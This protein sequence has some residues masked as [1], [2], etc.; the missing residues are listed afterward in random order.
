MKPILQTI[1]IIA[2]FF[3]L[4]WTNA[5]GLN[6]PQTELNQVERMLKFC[7]GERLKM[8]RS[9]RNMEKNPATVTLAEYNDA[10]EYLKE[11][12]KCIKNT[13]KALDELKK[14]YPEW[15]NNQSVTTNDRSGESGGSAEVYEQELKNLRVN[16]E[17][18][19]EAI[20]SV[21]IPNH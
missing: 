19:M 9:I 14:K 10:K 6:P 12:K 2:C 17:W 21:P 13:A 3:T 16:L 4:P 18:Y 8:E 11:L 20:N 5:Q 15:A 1:T 7:E